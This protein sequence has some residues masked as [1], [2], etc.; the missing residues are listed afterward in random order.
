MAGQERQGAIFDQQKMAMT[1][2]F[3]EFSDR[4]WE[5]QIMNQV[6]HPSA[7]ADQRC[8]LVQIDA[9]SLS[10]RVEA[11]VNSSGKQSFKL[12]SMKVGRKEDFLSSQVPVARQGIEGIPREI[13]VPGGRMVEGKRQLWMFSPRPNHARTQNWIGRSKEFVPAFRKLDTCVRCAVQTP[14]VFHLCRFD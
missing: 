8:H 9:H 14:K 12:N 13:K 3:R 4:S 5:A 1:A 6:D 2:Q 10:N 11:D 7:I